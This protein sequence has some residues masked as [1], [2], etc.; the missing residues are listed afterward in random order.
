MLRGLLLSPSFRSI[1][2]G[3]R[4]DSMDVAGLP[5]A[6]SRT[7]APSERGAA[8]A[9]TGRTRR[10]LKVELDRS[11]A[12]RRNLLLVSLPANDFDVLAPHLKDI[13]LEQGAVLQ[14][15]GERIEQVY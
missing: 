11:R 6:S 12:G 8:S 4:T 14:E 2:V 10:R 15:Q 9:R 7:G 3:Y 5:N 1:F 13:E